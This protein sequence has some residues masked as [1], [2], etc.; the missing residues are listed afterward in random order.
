[1]VQS[2]PDGHTHKHLK[3]EV[4]VNLIDDREYYATKLQLHLDKQDLTY[5]NAVIEINNRDDD[6]P[7]P[8]ALGD[9]VIG[10]ISLMTKIPIFII[11]PTVDRTTDVNDRPVMENHANIEYLFRQDANKAQTRSSD[12]VVMVY[13][14]LD[15]Y[16]PTLPREIA[17][18]SRNCAAASNLIEDAFSIVKKVIVELPSSTACESL[19]KCL[20]FMGAANSHLEGT[21][22][23][24]GTAVSAALP[25]DIPIP[26][27]AGPE[28]VAKTAHKCAASTFSEAPP[29][30]KKNESDEAFVGRKKK[31]AE[32]VQKRAD[33][34]TKLG[35]TQCPCSISYD[36]MEQLLA[37][38]AN[39]H[40]DKKVWK[41]T[42]CDSVSNSKSHLWTHARHHLG[43]YFYYCDCAYTDEKDLD[44]KGEAKKKI[45]EKGFNEVIGVEFH[46]EMH[47]GVGKCRCRCDYCDKPQQSN[48][49]KKE[50]HLSCDKGPNKDGGPTHWCKEENCGYSCRSSSSMKKHMETD[51]FAVVG[52]AVPKR[53][54]CK[55]CGKEF[56]SPQGWKRHDCTTPKVRKPRRRK[57]P[58]GKPK[59]IYL[60]VKL[61][62]FPTL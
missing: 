9:F 17:E 51:H 22:L 35:A 32:K 25:L 43:K 26:K 21:S 60:L 55:V 47:H 14:G 28:H 49:R 36:T 24:T 7:I 59:L 3:R 38:Q 50:H 4:L 15:Y 1:M 27:P 62:T 46:R 34:D 33:R 6:E 10:A 41:C 57:E 45:C 40:P 13:N 20:K 44:E 54:K 12:L 37:H 58:V 56:K 16:A 23:A 53:W 42:H 2:W 39:A 31:Y 48:R 30:K 8:A 19:S 29:E 61:S 5:K 18:F 11:Y 52:L